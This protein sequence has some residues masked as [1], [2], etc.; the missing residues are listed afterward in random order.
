[1]SEIT[2]DFFSF[3][4]PHAHSSFPLNTTVTV[5]SLRMLQEF[6]I[7]DFHDDVYRLV[8]LLIFRVADF[9]AILLGIL[10]LLLRDV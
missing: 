8:F 7:Y 6:L 5:H 1:M 2:A 10:L 4:T 9:R 3:S